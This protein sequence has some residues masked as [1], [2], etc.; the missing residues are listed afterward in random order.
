[1]PF[2][3]NFSAQSSMHLSTLEKYPFLYTKYY[4][5]FSRLWCHHSPVSKKKKNTGLKTLKMLKKNAKKKEKMD[6]IH[7]DERSRDW[8]RKSVMSKRLL[9]SQTAAPASFF[10]LNILH[11]LLNDTVYKIRWG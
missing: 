11:L 2:R 8:W 1:M 10:V 3:R 9:S 5:V 4:D 7:T 6:A